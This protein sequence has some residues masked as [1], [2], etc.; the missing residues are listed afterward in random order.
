MVNLEKIML[1]EVSQIP[2]YRYVI[3]GELVFNGYRVSCT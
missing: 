3:I 2:N 1:S